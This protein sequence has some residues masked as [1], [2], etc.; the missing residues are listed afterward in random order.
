LRTTFKHLILTAVVCL[1]SA[2]LISCGG[3]GGGANAARSSGGV[4]FS[5]QWPAHSRLI[6]KAAMFVQAVLT[7]AP[8]G[9]ST[10]VSNLFAYPASASSTGDVTVSYPSA[11]ENLGAGAW[12]ASV[13]SYATDPTASGATVQND[14]PLS[15]ATTTLTVSGGT[16]TPLSVTL[17][18]TLDHFTI[19]GLAPYNPAYGA[20]VNV[21]SGTPLTLVR[22]STTDATPPSITITP[23]NAAG[24]MLLISSQI[25]VSISNSNSGTVA[26]SGTG[27]VGNLSVSSNSGTAIL[28]INYTDGAGTDTVNSN[29]NI[30]LTL[31]NTA[32]S[33][34]GVTA[35]VQNWPV[36]EHAD[37]SL[38]ANLDGAYLVLQE[39]SGNGITGSLYSGLVS[40]LSITDANVDAGPTIGSGV[41]IDHGNTFLPTVVAV[42]NS[43]Q[44]NSIP[45][46]EVQGAGILLVDFN[47]SHAIDLSKFVNPGETAQPTFYNLFKIST[48]NSYSV[49]SGTLGTISS[50][51]IQPDTS[52]LPATTPP[53]PVPPNAGYTT[54][55][56]P[57]KD[58]TLSLPSGS[59]L[60]NLTYNSGAGTWS[61]QTSTAP[62]TTSQSASINVVYQVRDSAGNVETLVS[63]TIAV[64]VNPNA[65]SGSGIIN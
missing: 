39:A 62:I 23:E 60:S 25:T 29:F 5:I 53:T 22:S 36:A 10:P 11:F 56:M 31:S 9:G 20:G 43:T 13:N 12:T 1:L 44:A 65:G 17:V 19:T 45:M 57:A 26:Y 3:G 33:T 32:A 41:V 54:Q 6:P 35:Y 59:I 24:A 27:T 61:F 30:P 18:S 49:T 7:P 55:A 40:P 2:S 46:F 14:P 21:I 37:N 28:T 50:V 52:N 48:T 8:G 63:G 34:T 42:A 16:N 51:T 4:S 15:S 47:S 64:T 38:V 58:F